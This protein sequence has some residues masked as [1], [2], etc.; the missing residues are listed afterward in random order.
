MNEP[1]KLI[2]A[3][4]KTGGHLFPGIAVAQA[5]QR[6][7]P[8]ADILFVGTRA[9]FE[10][11]TLKSYGFAHRAI[12]SKPVKG[13][14]LLHKI[15]ALGIVSVSL[16]QSI[17]IM[18]GMK[19]DFVLGVGGFSSFAVVLAAWLMNIPT[20]VQEQNTIP[21]MTNRLLARFTRTIFT[22]F[23]QTQD[24]SENPK[25]K[26]VGNPVRRPEPTDD[27]LCR[28]CKDLDPDRFTLLITGGSQ[29]AHSINHAVIDALARMEN[30]EDINIIHQTGVSDESFARNQYRQLGIQA[31]ARAFFTRMP[32]IMA[33]ADLIIARAGAGTLAELAIN[34][35]PALLVPFPHAADDHQTVN[36]EAF[37]RQGAAV[38]IKD[39][40]LSGQTVKD[41]VEDLFNDRQKLTEMASAMKQLAMPDADRAIARHI[42]QTKGDGK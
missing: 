30:L 5:V 20:A 22:A 19:P 29:G 1:F 17:G 21:G 34:G 23:K 9:P 15:S 39:N 7:T 38:V 3:G 10:T 26:F 25:T 33:S 36:A 32:Q 4:G 31:D 41:L 28:T 40:Q 6:M 18:I 12:W 11:S 16:V 24:F 13:G 42:L 2:I 8:R 14:S 27:K 35:K 37:A